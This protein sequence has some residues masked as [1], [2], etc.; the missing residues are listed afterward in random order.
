MALPGI[1]LVCQCVFCQ[2]NNDAVRSSA[3]VFLFAAGFFGT[4]VIHLAIEE[5]GVYVASATD[6]EY[7]PLAPENAESFLLPL[8]EVVLSGG[9]LS[10]PFYLCTLLYVASITL[11]FVLFRKV[12]RKASA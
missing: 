12:E 1:P 11:F 6:L 8:L 2:N 5:D 9:D 10:L 3:S 4:N 7:M